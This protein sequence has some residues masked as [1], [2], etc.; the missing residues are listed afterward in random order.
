M[1]F[2]DRLEAFGLDFSLS[3]ASRWVLLIIDPML[4]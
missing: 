2:T 4:L 3:K 1:L